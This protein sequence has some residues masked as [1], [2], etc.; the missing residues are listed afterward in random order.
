LGGCAHGRILRPRTENF[1]RDT[2]CRIHNG[3]NAESVPPRGLGAV[4]LPFRG[5]ETTMMRVEA[6]NEYRP[7]I[8][9]PIPAN[10]VEMV[11]EQVATRPEATATQYKAGGQWRSHT[12]KELWEEIRAVGAALL[13]EGVEVGDRVAIL[14]ATRVEHA[15]ADL[16]ILAA[17]GSTVPLYQS[18]TPDEV[19]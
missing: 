18:H 10:V 1:A 19:R 16:G 8:P 7:A 9:F 13:A 5:A 11:K 6:A 14:S 15:I 12:W 17:R 3:R 4:L 2:R